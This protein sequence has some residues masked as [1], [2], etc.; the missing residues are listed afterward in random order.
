MAVAALAVAEVVDLAVVVVASVVV[1]VAVDYV[2]DNRVVLDQHRPH[3]LIVQSAVGLHCV[4]T[5][6]RLQLNQDLIAS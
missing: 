3:H 1:A 5:R 4:T 2:Y 6:L